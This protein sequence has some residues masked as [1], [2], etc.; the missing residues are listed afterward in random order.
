[1]ALAFFGAFGHFPSG[2]LAPYLHGRFEGPPERALAPEDAAFGFFGHFPST[3]APYL[4]GR[5]DEAERK[6]APPGI[7]LDFGLTGLNESSPSRSTCRAS[8]RPSTTPIGL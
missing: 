5:F 1:M 8:Q 3:R 7:A 6:G 2:V 4:H